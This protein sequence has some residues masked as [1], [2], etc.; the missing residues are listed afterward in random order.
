M[1]YILSKK[2]P[3]IILLGVMMI[4]FVCVRFYKNSVYGIGVSHDSIFYINLANGLLQ[5]HSYETHFGKE[6]L[7]NTHYPPLYSAI[8]AFLSLIVSQPIE[9]VALI[10]NIFLYVLNAIILGLIVRKAT[11]NNLYL[12]IIGII[13]FFLAADLYLVHFHLWTEPLYLFLTNL[14]FLMLLNYQTSDNKNWKYFIISVILLGLA[15][16]TRY[17]GITAIFVCI[18]WLIYHNFFENYWVNKG[19][20]FS[21]FSFKILKNGIAFGIISIAPL[22][23]WLMRNKIQSNNLTSR[24]ITYEAITEKILFEGVQTIKN[25]VVNKYLQEPIMCYFITIVFVLF[26]FIIPVLLKLNKRLVINYINQDNLKIVTLLLFYIFVYFSFLIVNKMYIDHGTPMDSRILTPI[27]FSSI[28]LLII[29]MYELNI[30]LKLLCKN[31]TIYMGSI[32]IIGIIICG[33][34][35]SNFKYRNYYAFEQKNEGHGFNSKKNIQ[36]EYIDILK[37]IPADKRIF[38]HSGNFEFYYLNYLSKRPIEKLIDF[39]KYENKMN[40][41]EIYV[42]TFTPEKDLKFS[43]I[44]NKIDTIFPEHIYKLYLP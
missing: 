1:Q 10:F 22:L 18:L 3:I 12:M 41:K 8:L 36:L 6:V 14:G 20:I 23:F 2:K 26:L 13:S 25:W 5:F 4:V 19:N 43:I 17:V 42:T 24:E 35:L 32:G 27:F 28:I 21:I 9:Q 37:K 38:L 7:Y 30:L 31:N 33:I 34:M 44:Y 39:E 29:G 15:C 11:N 16:I 40:I